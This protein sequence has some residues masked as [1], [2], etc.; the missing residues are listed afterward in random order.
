M[1][2]IKLVIN[3]NTETDRAIQDIIDDKQDAET[4]KKDN[5][6][7]NSIQIKSKNK[8]LED[9]E[10]VVVKS[11]AEREEIRK[12]NQKKKED[13]KK[14]KE[15]ET[16]FNIL[17]LK[18]NMVYN[19]MNM[20]GFLNLI[21]AMYLQLIF[22]AFVFA[23]HYKREMGFLNIFFPILIM[24]FGL[25]VLGQLFLI[26]S[27]K[28]VGNK[29]Y[30]DKK[31]VEDAMLAK[32]KEDEKEIIRKQLQSNN[33]GG[34]IAP[35]KKKQK[36]ELNEQE[37]N[38]STLI[39]LNKNKASKGKTK[40]KGKKKEIVE[41][42]YTKEINNYNPQYRKIYLDLKLDRAV[43]RYYPFIELMSS[44]LFII[45]IVMLDQ[46]LIVQTLILMAIQLAIVLYLSKV[47]P[48]ILQDDNMRDILD[49]SFN[50]IIIGIM[51]L[52]A[53]N[54]KSNFIDENTKV[55][56][57]ER[58]FMMIFFVLKLVALLVLL[59]LK[60]YKAWKKKK[61]KKVEPVVVAS[62]E[63]GIVIKQNTIQVGEIQDVQG[64]LIE[65]RLGQ[66]DNEIQENRPEGFKVGIK[67]KIND[68]SVRQHERKQMARE[69][70]QKNVVRKKKV[71]EKEDDNI[72][73]YD[74]EFKM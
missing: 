55:R 70:R 61:S 63:Q 66:G 5:D 20:A 18:I 17:I 56:V 50:L 57:L 52:F 38:D 12:Q 69:G 40:G 11:K 14:K 22:L 54:D 51:F 67:R 31:K 21:R 44:S 30:G 60:I 43:V 68:K 53:V 45:V 74:L 26:G 35:D 28:L 71:D 25:F 16:K 29:S 42:D 39:A 24:I 58:G 37:M 19:H 73:F 2:I 32:Q 4:V 36:G 7:D 6:N 3:S 34:H 62:K 72:K 23:R 48:Y 47:K 65:N 49:R 9:D 59:I 64:G 1:V 8:N 15:S 10:P 33:V 46:S 41:I 13:F 27:Y